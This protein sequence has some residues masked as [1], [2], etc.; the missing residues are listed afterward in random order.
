AITAL[1]IM[2]YRRKVLLALLQQFG[3]ELKST[4]MQKMLLVFT[5]Q[6]QKPA[7]E[8]VPYKYGAYSFHARSDKGT[9]IKYELLKDSKRWVLNSDEDYTGQLKKTDRQILK[10]L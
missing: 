6:Q 10:N 3:G 2:Y 4:P 7:Y 5:R 1:I 8:F 9:M